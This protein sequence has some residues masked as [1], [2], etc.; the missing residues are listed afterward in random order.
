MVSPVYYKYIG[1]SET[2]AVIKEMCDIFIFSIVNPVNSSKTKMRCFL[3]HCIDLYFTLII[4]IINKEILKVRTYI[5]FYIRCQ[6]NVPNVLV[7][8]N[9]MMLQN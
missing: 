3:I 1:T 8:I 7:H 4:S 2:S 5:G 9:V 6:F